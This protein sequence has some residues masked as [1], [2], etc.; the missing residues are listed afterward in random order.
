MKHSAET[1]PAPTEQADRD[2]HSADLLTQTQVCARLGISD[3]TWRRWRK[4]GRTPEQV[5]LPGRPRWRRRDID[6]LVGP[7]TREYFGR[8]RRS[9]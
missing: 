3:E 2:A 9:A 4:A 8:G 7:V 6:R 5:Q 1:L